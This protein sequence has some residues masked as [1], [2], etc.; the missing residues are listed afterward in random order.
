MAKNV[1]ILFVSLDDSTRLIW[2]WK[3]PNMDYSLIYEYDVFQKHIIL[4]FLKKRKKEKQ[5]YKFK[6]PVESKRG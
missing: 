3:T 1:I 2:G 6:F 4:I 5:I